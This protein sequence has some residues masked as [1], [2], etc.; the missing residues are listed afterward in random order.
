MRR[1]L[2]M[3]FRYAWDWMGQRTSRIIIINGSSKIEMVWFVSLHFFS[4]D[5][6][7][8]LMICFNMR[9]LACELLCNAV[10]LLCYAALCC[11][12]RINLSSL[13]FRFINAMSHNH[14]KKYDYNNCSR[15]RSKSTQLKPI[16]VCALKNAWIWIG[17]VR[18]LVK[19]LLLSHLVI[20]WFWIS[21]KLMVK[22]NG[23]TDKTSQTNIMCDW[24][25]WF[26]TLRRYSTTSV[27]ALKINSTCRFFVETPSSPYA[28][29]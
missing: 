29:Q 2:E 20:Q 8:A 15:P 27:L 10:V 21:C 3:I 17:S 19:S 28:I 12:F 18:I 1:I 23:Y 11:A 13:S 14:Q 5:W 7:W 26:C 24:F 4:Y 16:R 6:H 25:M 22:V 9:R